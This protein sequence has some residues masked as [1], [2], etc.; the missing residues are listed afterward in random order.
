MQRQLPSLLLLV[1]ALSTAPIAAQTAS[2]PTSGCQPNETRDAESVLFKFAQQFQPPLPT[3]GSVAE[4]ALSQPLTSAPSRQVAAPAK[5]GDTTSLINGASFPELLGLAFENGLVNT[6]QGVTTLDLNLFG[7][8][9]LA[10]PKVLDKDSEYRRQIFE[11]LRRLGGSV[12]FGGM[13]DSFDRNGDGVA[14]PAIDAKSP[15]DIVNWEVRWR[16]VGSRDRRESINV[17]KIFGEAQADFD[18][19]SRQF[20]DFFAGHAKDLE[21]L[22]SANGC[23]PVEKLNQFAQNHINELRAIVASNARLQKAINTANTEIDRS[24]V[25]TIA[26]G[27]VDRRKQFGPTKRTLSLRF[28]QGIFSGQDFTANLDYSHIHG[29]NGDL[30]QSWK[31]GAAWSILVLKGLQKD[32][33][34][35]SLSAADEYYRNVPMTHDS[36]V[37]LNAKLDFPVSKGIKIPLSFTWANHRDL[38]TSEHEMRG[39]IGFTVDL[40]EFEKKSGS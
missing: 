14:D 17:E 33:V 40:S 10:S 11:R 15:S 18:T 16:L 8:V 13:G 20:L 30:M 32:G 19:T 9:A 7:F 4:E 1:A 38:L 29:L 27:G 25:L 2:T 39:H 21:Q 12:S 24:R 6:A 23:F 34:K 35:L 36:I 37:K 22:Q 28:A 26:L 31:L 5:D 3:E